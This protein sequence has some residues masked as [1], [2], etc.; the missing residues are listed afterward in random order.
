M[1]KMSVEHFAKEFIKIFPESEEVYHQ[2]I[3]DY[4]ELLGH[5]FFGNEIDQTLSHLLFENKDIAKIQKYIDFIETMYSTGDDSVQNIVE[6]TILAYLGD[7]DTV[8]KH[9]FTYFSEDIIKAS[10]SIEEGY[11]RRTIII[12][13]RRGKVLTRW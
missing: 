7:D 9:A 8:L 6:V 10:K 12:S 5:V 2:H 3:K 1:E 13:Y 4:G 11:G